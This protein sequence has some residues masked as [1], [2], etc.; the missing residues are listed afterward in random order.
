MNGLKDFRWA[1][2]AQKHLPGTRLGYWAGSETDKKGPITRSEKDLILYMEK[3]S[4]Y[5]I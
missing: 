1:G 3:R 4:G 2:P 5:V